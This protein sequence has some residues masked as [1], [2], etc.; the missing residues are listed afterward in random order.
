MKGWRTI[1]VNC[2]VAVVGVLASVSWPDVVGVEYAGIA[3]TAVSIVNMGL[4]LVTTT[5]IGQR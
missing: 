1:I 3:A 2:A 4:R 5:P